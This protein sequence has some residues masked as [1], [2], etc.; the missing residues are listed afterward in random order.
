MRSESLSQSSPGRYAKL[1][2]REAKI[3]SPKRSLSRSCDRT[4]HAE[5]HGTTMGDGTD[6]MG[7]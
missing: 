6:E 5:K 3:F 4:W 1:L 2:K 7:K